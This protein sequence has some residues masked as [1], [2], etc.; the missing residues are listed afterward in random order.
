MGIFKKVPETIVFVQKPLK[1]FRVAQISPLDN[2]SQISGQLNCYCKDIE[3]IISKI[4]HLLPTSVRIK[5]YCYLNL[6]CTYSTISFDAYRINRQMN[7]LSRS[8]QWLFI[9]PLIQLEP[10]DITVWNLIV[11]V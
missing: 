10:K 8:F 2:N 6:D 7:Y 5:K 9:C 11:L 3:E 1:S 4:F